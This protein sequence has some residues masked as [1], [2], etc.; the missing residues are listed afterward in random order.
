MRSF[1][2]ANDQNGTPASAALANTLSSMSVML[3]MK[4]TLNPECRNQR[5][6]TS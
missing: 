3:R 4:V 1:V 5:C 2:Y 6:S